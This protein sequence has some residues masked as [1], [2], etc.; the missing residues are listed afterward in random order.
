[1][2]FTAEQQAQFPL[3]RA[4]LLSEGILHEMY[5]NKPSLF[6]FLQARQWD[7]EKATLMYRNHMAWRKEIG[8]DVFVP[9]EAGPIPKFVLELDLPEIAEIKKHYPFGYHRVTKEGRPLYFD[10]L[11]ALDYKK[12]VAFSSMERVITYF[13]WYA[14]ASQQFR[15]PAASLACGKHIGKSHFIVDMKGF[16]IGK[17]NGDTRGFIKAFNGIA[18]DNYPECMHKTYIINAPFVFQAAWSVVS[19]MLDPQTVAKF[20]IVTTHP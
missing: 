20:S 11:G 19:K 5:D 17:L 7:I 16:S 3:L 12:M 8:L 14:E 18:S 9:T 2:K 4:K 6:R 10:R 13:T 1:M 15:N